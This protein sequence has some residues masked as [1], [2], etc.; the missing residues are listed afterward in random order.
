MHF[1]NLMS[2][3]TSRFLDFESRVHAYEAID[4][5]CALT[6]AA[7]EIFSPVIPECFQTLFAFYN[8][9]SKSMYIIWLL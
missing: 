7:A 9:N 3:H 5:H 8:T 1:S 2:V 4:R 6:M